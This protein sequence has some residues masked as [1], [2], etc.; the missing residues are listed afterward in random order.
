MRVNL[1]RCDSRSANLDYA[2]QDH[3]QLIGADLVKADL[4]DTILL[5]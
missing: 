4:A 1:T 2:D 5:G 3:A